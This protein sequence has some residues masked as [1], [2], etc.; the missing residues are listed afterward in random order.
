MVIGQLG[1]VL[2]CDRSIE[3][4]GFSSGVCG[5]GADYF[6]CEFAGGHTSCL[7]FNV[8]TEVWVETDGLE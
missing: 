4:S 8:W 3:L 6:V 5:Y 1:R 7:F 2:F